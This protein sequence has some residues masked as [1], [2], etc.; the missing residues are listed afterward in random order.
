MILVEKL[1]L[2]Y[3]FFYKSFFPF[4]MLRSG[5]SKLDGSGTSEKKEIYFDEVLFDVINNGIHIVGY[6]FFFHLIQYRF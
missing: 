5:G 2:L 6:V 4:V 1:F 3:P